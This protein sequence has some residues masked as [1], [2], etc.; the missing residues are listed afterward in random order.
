MLVPPERVLPQGDPGCRDLDG[1]PA[2]TAP[3]RG[4][5][6]PQ[7]RPPR[8]PRPHASRPAPGPERIAPLVVHS[9]ALARAP[10][11][12]ARRVPGRPRGS[13]PRRRPQQAAPARLPRGREE[14]RSKASTGPPRHP[15]PGRERPGR[16]RTGWRSRSSSSA[17]TVLVVRDGWAPGW[18]AEVD[19]RREPVAR[20]DGRHRAVAVPAGRSTVVLRYRPPGL[21]PSLAGSA[22]GALVRGD[23]PRGAKRPPRPWPR[24]AGPRG[25]L[26][27]SSPRPGPRRTGSRHRELHLPNGGHDGGGRGLRSASVVRSPAA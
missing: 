10:A 14:P 25:G 17:P 6:P 3:R 22:A 9:Y 27:A 23:R 1:P 21:C 11:P 19:G 24:G 4:A 20:A 12:R 8:P 5:D 2:A 13:T 16:A 26:W 15:G 18:T 7:R